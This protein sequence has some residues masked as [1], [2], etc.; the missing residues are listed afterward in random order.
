MGLLL[1]TK[2]KNYKIFYSMIIFILFIIAVAVIAYQTNLSHQIHDSILYKIKKL[3]NKQLSEFTV[4]TDI[5]VT[6]NNRQIKDLETRFDQFENRIMKQ[7][8]LLLEKQPDITNL[9][10]EEEEESCSIAFVLSSAHSGNEHLFSL[11]SN[12]NAKSMDVYYQAPPNM[13]GTELLAVKTLGLNN[14]YYTRKNDKIK[15]IEQQM[16]N[17]VYVDTSHLFIESW[18]DV[19]L[20]HFLIQK[21]CNVT[22]IILQRYLPAVIQEL[23]NEGFVDNERNWYHSYQSKIA[24]IPELPYEGERVR[25]IDNI[26]WYLLDIQNKIENIKKKYPQATYLGM[27]V[28]VLDSIDSIKWLL[29]QLNVNV[30]ND[31]VFKQMNEINL[32]NYIQNMYKRTIMEVVEQYNKK[33]TPIYFDNSTLIEY[34]N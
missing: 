4:L 12:N 11:L 28:E 10:E 29:N 27:R 23:I 7:L 16:T 14:T 15:A 33:G 2:T 3:T 21:Q 32:S 19:V 34:I 22:M 13:G 9:I 5:K 18:Y 30:P 25:T 1:Y 31:I 8:Q 20:D 26:I 17:R 24:T 6:E